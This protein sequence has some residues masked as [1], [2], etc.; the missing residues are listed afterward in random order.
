MN[1]KKILLRNV[2][3][4]KFQTVN[5]ASS[6]RVDDFVGD[7]TK[8][9]EIFYSEAVGISKIEKGSKD[10]VKAE[11]KK[12]YE[13]NKFKALFDNLNREGASLTSAIELLIIDKRSIQ[14]LILGKK[15][16]FG[17]PLDFFSVFCGYKGWNSFLK[18]YPNAD[19]EIQ[20]LVNKDFKF[21]LT[22]TYIVDGKLE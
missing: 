17:A 6:L 7:F 8:N 4:N 5:A 20:E 19:I 9:I 3:L 2:V 12:T 22:T 1:P 13:S 10:G 11:I 21:A 16:N 14:K 18:N 15:E